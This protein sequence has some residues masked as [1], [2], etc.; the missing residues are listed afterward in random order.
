MMMR[1]MQQQLLEAD[2]IKVT[3]GRVDLKVYGIAD[4][5]VEE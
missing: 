3:D 5:A 4:T 1:A 2:G